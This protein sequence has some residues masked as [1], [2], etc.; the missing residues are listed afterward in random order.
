MFYV[1]LA[2]RCKAEFLFPATKIPTG[3][4]YRF[5]RSCGARSPLPTHPK[6]RNTLSSFVIT[7]DVS[8]RVKHRLHPDLEAVFSVA[9]ACLQDSSESFEYPATLFFGSVDAVA[10]E[11][12]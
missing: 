11:Y 8:H 12:F 1:C 9:D 3:D 2:S 7:G 6:N 4:F 10:G 5:D